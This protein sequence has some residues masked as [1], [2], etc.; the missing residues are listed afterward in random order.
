M[1]CISDLIGLLRDFILTNIMKPL[2]YFMVY[3]FYLNTL[4]REYYKT[5]VFR[6]YSRDL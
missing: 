4:L 3:I 1:V 2:Y 5:I 6:V